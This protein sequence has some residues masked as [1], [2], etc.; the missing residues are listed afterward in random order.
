MQIAPFPSN[1]PERLAALQQC[2]ILDTLPER[3]F[4]DITQ[5][6][7]C[8]CQTPIALVSLIDSDR[9]WFKS[10][11]GLETA[12]TPRKL[13][14]CAH[15]ILQRDVLIV[16]DTL[17][18]ERFADNPLTTDEPH[19][20]FYAGVPLIT[21]EG[22]ALGTLC[23]I[24]HV[25]RQLSPEQVNAL[26][27]LG[28]QVVDQLEM[29]RNLA[30]VGRT[31]VS[32]TSTFRLL[33]QPKT[34]FKWIVNGCVAALVVL[35]VA[36]IK[37]SPI[38]TASKFVLIGL[39]FYYIYQGVTKRQ[40]IANSLE[41]ERDFS[42]A[43]LDTTA[44]LVVIIDPSGRIVRFN[45]RCE[46]VSGYSFAEVRNKLFWKILL[47][48]D[49]VKSV[50]AVFTQV[51]LS[52]APS[53]NENHWMTRTGDL[54]LIAWANTNLTDA[55]GKIKYIISTGIDITEKKRAE[56]ELRQAEAKYRSI[57]ENSVEGIFQTTPAGQYLS[58][59]PALAR[60]YG[61]DS[62]EEMMVAVTDI[63]HQIYV[64]P[65]R[66]LKMVEL[67][68][69]CDQV[70]EFEYKAYR[71]DGSII[72]ISE[73]VRAARDATGELL[74]YEGSTVDISDRK[75]S[76][77]ARKQIQEQELQQRK[78]LAQQ[79][80]ELELARRQAE[81]AAQMKSIFLATMS[82]EIRTPMNAV[83]GM[84]G[85][86]LDTTL[87]SQQRDFAETIRIS[88]DNLLTL[89]NE[90]L[91]FSKLEAGEMELE[92]LDFNL[93]SCVEEV[94]DL[95][96]ASAHAKGLEIATL[97]NSDVPN[98][99][100]GDVSRLRQVLTNLVGNAIKFTEMGEVMIQIA[101]ESETA[102]AATV[103][104]SVNDTGMGIASEA[105]K[106][107][108]QP[109]SQ[110]DASTTRRF[111][112]TGLGLAICK[113]LVELMGGQICV[114]SVEE[115]GSQF[116]FVLTL[117]KQPAVNLSPPTVDLKGLRLL[118]VDDNATNRKI[119]KHQA[120]AWGMQVDE[121]ADAETAIAVMRSRA[122]AEAPYDIAIL[123][124]QMPEVDGEMLGQ[125][126]KADPLLSATRLVMLTSINQRGE[127]KRVQELGFSAYLIK[128]VKQS[129]LFD[130]LIEVMNSEA[131]LS[132]EGS[133]RSSFQSAELNSPAFAHSALSS[134]DSAENLE[135]FPIKKL[136]ILLA[137]DSLI[138]Q[139]VALNQL[140]NLGYEADVAANGEEVLDLM[141][142]IDYDLILMDCQMPIMDGYITTQTI[143]QLQNHNGH[144][145][146]I[147]MTANAMKTDQAKCI[148]AGMDDYLS[149]PVQKKVLG[150]KLAY[151][152]QLLIAR[153]SC[154]HQ[155]ATANCNNQ[156]NC[157]NQPE[158]Q[159]ETC[160]GFEV[161]IDWEYLHQLSGDNRA[162]EQDI[163]Q[164]LM[165]TL[166]THLQ[167]LNAKVLAED[168]SGIERE[169][170]YIKGSCASVGAIALA[171]HAEVLEQKARSADLTDADKVLTAM[172]QTFKQTVEL[173]ELS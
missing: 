52:H 80:Q 6:A 8:V 33:S 75:R 42:T 114:K 43:V 141:T 137:E 93:V 165:E 7:V 18:D 116:Q 26:K 62:P 96:A 77:E 24:D 38:G 166:P 159:L 37:T 63:T 95:L 45:H 101:L 119:V 120:T 139:K 170:H 102:T 146:I 20:R 112:G 82:H 15:T 12:E 30:E 156:S 99:L 16:P 41:Q 100:R 118:V 47:H 121:A 54:R 4:D 14:F 157:N 31:V 91:D 81:Q 125:I 126:F 124:A 89:L 173:I 92:V 60:L 148:A 123:D 73:R 138:N 79:N 172:T 134:S 87:D 51:K 163:L 106:K 22:Y 21:S 128:P 98:Y 142:K 2:K 127:T 168:Y 144:T 35:L 160:A 133:D 162:F 171:D 13:A 111:G 113:Q 69:V 143:R 88:G 107:L 84:T 61:Y 48:P 122:L 72:W 19:I 53:T 83:L 151:W 17:A 3:G 57:F 71:K 11:V 85:L 97:V 64:N 74:Y 39:A 167:S 90:I 50:K 23:V 40:R 140:K 78:Q 58:A 44:A 104:I 29:R 161:L 25:P 46:E 136:K 1:E 152:S 129:R 149:K 154:V 158:S 132:A 155:T 76:E 70:S 145:L 103:H 131:Q 109:F 169:A 65:S 27:A 147:A 86:L 49:E 36:N 110:V 5:V 117:E 150:E 164:A 28:R 10:R 32:S 153:E 105:Q 9:Q 67:M 66:R 94:A 56:Q 59:N 55:D 68:K 135:G 108:F 130:C 34:W 115:Q